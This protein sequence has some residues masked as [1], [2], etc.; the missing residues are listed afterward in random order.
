MDYE[1]KV[2]LIHW[3][4]TRTGSDA[5]EKLEPGSKARVQAHYAAEGLTAFEIAEDALKALGHPDVATWVR[6]TLPAHIK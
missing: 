3:I 6:L 5:E 1:D 2:R 4:I